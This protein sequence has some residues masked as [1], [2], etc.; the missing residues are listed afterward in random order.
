MVFAIHFKWGDIY[1]PRFR[2]D[3]IIPRARRLTLSV[4]SVSVRIINLIHRNYVMV[5]YSNVPRPPGFKA[6]KRH[7]WRD[8][9]VDDCV[10]YPAAEAKQ[11]QMAATAYKRNHPGWDYESHTRDGVTTIWR[12][13]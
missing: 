10:M 4:S 11:A 1:G 5:V 6:R 13:S 12:L 7:E 9:G 2:G 8:M 3:F